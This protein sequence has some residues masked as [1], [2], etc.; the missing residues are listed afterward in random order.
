[1]P[2]STVLH[3]NLALTCVE[4]LLYGIFFVLA[5]TSLV[6]LVAHRSKNPNG[7]SSLS[8]GKTLLSSPLVIGTL[9]LFITVGG[10]SRSISFPALLI[11]SRFQHWCTTVVRLFQSIDYDGGQHMEY[12]YLMVELTPQVV[13]TAFVVASVIVGDIILVR[14]SINTVVRVFHVFLRRHTDVS[15]VG[16]VG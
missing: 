15:C 12:Y 10:V 3:V 7:S 4:S 2:S 16:S 9:L 6:V 14:A 5:I 1:M 8:V 11:L 13:A